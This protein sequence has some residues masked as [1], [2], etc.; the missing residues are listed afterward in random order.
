MLYVNKIFARGEPDRV[1]FLC[2]DGQ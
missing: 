2:H 1:L